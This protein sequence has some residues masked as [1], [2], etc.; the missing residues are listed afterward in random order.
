MG[1]GQDV[2][3]GVPTRGPTVKRYDLGAMKSG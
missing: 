1:I 3:A 2:P